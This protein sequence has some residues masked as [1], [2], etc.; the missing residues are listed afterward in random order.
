M[1][2]I[3]VDDYFIFNFQFYLIKYVFSCRKTW[4]YISLTFSIQKKK[5][6][7]IIKGKK[8]KCLGQWKMAACSDDQKNGPYSKKSTHSICH[9]KL[10][11]Y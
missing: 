11:M 1:F 9:I 7:K 2:Q 8:L 6:K 4:E 3:S 10:N 5:R